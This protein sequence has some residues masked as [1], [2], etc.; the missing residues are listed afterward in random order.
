MFLPNTVEWNNNQFSRSDW[1]DLYGDI[2]QEVPHNAHEEQELIVQ[3]IVF[4]ELYHAGKYYMHRS[5][6][7]IILFLNKAPVIWFSK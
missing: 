6:I 2:K 7:G 3:H 1:T 5:N 4:V